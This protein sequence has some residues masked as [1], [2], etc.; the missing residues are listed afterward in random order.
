MYFFKIRKLN[1]YDAIMYNLSKKIYYSDIFVKHREGGA[2]QLQER[3]TT[4]CRPSGGIA[5]F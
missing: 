2:L 3:L 4:M 1:N 5:S